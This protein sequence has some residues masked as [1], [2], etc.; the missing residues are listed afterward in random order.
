MWPAFTNL[1]YSASG[2]VGIL[3]QTDEIKATVR[4]AMYFMEEFIIFENAFPDLATRATWARKALLKA[5]NHLSQSKLTDYD[6][7]LVIKK[8]IKEDPDYVRGL[9][10]VVRQNWLGDQC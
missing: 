5:V 9:S 1:A 6:Q 4:K 8:R 3:G 2:K 10:S 7:Y